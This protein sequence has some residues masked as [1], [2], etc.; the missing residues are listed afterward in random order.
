MIC[1]YAGNDKLVNKSGGIGMIAINPKEYGEKLYDGEYVIPGALLGYNEGEE[2]KKYV[3]SVP[4]PTATIAFG[5]TKLHVE[6][7]PVVVYFSSRGPN[8]VTPGILKPDLIAPGNEILAGWS[9]G[10]GPYSPNPVRFNIASGTSMA[11]PHVSGLV[12]WLKGPTQIGA[13]L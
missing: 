11:C 5:F 9:Q 3:F 13:L 7:S 10:L 8:P 12:A 2:L 4:N 6:P 1:D